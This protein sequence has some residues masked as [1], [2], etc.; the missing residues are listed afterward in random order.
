MTLIYGLEVFSL[1]NK[2]GESRG[3]NIDE[4]GMI[5]LLFKFIWSRIT[6]NYDED[7]SEVVTHTTKPRKT[8]VKSTSEKEI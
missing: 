4:V 8:R 2:Y 5:K 7:F 3:I 6:G 1:L